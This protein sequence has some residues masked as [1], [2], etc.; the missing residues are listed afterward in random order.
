M[1]IRIVVL[2]LTLVLAGLTQSPGVSAQKAGKVYQF[3]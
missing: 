3:G 1:T 2:V